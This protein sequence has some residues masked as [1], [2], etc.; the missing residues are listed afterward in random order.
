MGQ[1]IKTQ[2]RFEVMGDDIFKIV[3]KILNNQNLLKLVKYTDNDPLA[4]EDIPQDE[5][6]KMLHKDILITP[7]IPDEDDDKNCYI[8]VLLD[9]YV[10]DAENKDFKVATVR[11]DVL[12]PM[13]RWVIN[14]KS[15]RPYLIMNEIDKEFNEKKL[16]GIGNLSFNSA[17][18]LVVS[19]Y[20]AG[21][22]LK[23]GHSEFN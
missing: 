13:D 14:G 17:E 11:F 21:Y 15:L 22:S 5:I 2:R 9:N 3:N 8:I 4:H 16:A 6:D 10:V 23:Y 18:R 12:C 20:L 19:A 1:E 7:K